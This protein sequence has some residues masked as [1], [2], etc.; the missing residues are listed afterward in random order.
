MEINRQNLDFL[1]TGYKAAF[2]EAFNGAEVD[3]D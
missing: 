3:Y 1:F 2:Q